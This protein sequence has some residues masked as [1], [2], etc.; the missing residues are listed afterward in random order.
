MKNAEPAQPSRAEDRSTPP[1]YGGAFRCIGP[2]CEDHCCGGWTIPV[3]KKKY[4]QYLQFPADGLGAIVAQSVSVVDANGPEEL[5]ARINP[6]IA[7]ACAFFEED[8]L[9]AIQKQ[10]GQDLLPT[11]CSVYPRVLNRVDGNL[12]GSLTLSCPEAARNILLDPNAL[13][14]ESDLL[15]GDFQTSN[16]F[17]LAG[18][19]SSMHKPS[20]SFLAIRSLVI[21]MA[22]DRARPIWQRL[23]LIGVLCERL[24]QVTTPVTTPEDDLQVAA[25]LAEYQSVVEKGGLKTELDALPSATELQLEVL[26]RLTIERMQNHTG[27]DRFRRTCEEFLLGIGYENSTPA[28]RTH[29]YRHALRTYHQPFFEKFPFILENYLL[30]TIFQTLF[31]FGRSGSPHCVP[32]TIMDEYILFAVQFAWVNALLIGMAGHYK[33]NFSGAHVVFTIQ[34]FA[35]GVEHYPWFVLSLLEHCRSLQLNSLNGMAVL[36]KN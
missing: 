29:R 36:L 11:T 16:V 35:R 21:A 6:P 2:G 28:E 13:Q 5:Y 10:Y 20:Q 18:S 9:C 34:S 7:G 30:N 22:R 19:T 25:I 3:D 12:E 8:R 14:V 32:Q 27:S 23:L 33:E 17:A 15:A 1:T 26:L 4:Q 31:P 24:A